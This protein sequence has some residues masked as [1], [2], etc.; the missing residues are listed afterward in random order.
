MKQRHTFHGTSWEALED[1]QL[2]STASSLSAM[3][4]AALHANRAALLA[5]RGTAAQVAAGH[6]HT[7]SK[8]SSA[9]VAHLRTLRAKAA[10]THATTTTTT[11]TTD[12]GTGLAAA[13]AY[14][15]TVTANTPNSPYS[16]S[17]GLAALSPGSYP[18]STPVGTTTVRTMSAPQSAP[19]APVSTTITTPATT[20]TTVTLGSTST[21]STMTTPAVTGAT[22]TGSTGSVAV[23]TA[24]P[25][26]LGL[27]DGATLSKA[28]VAG[29]KTAVATFAAS[30]TYG[31][32]ATKDQA[33]AVA[34]EAAF[35]E[36]TLTAWSRTQVVPA[37][38]VTKLQQAINS[39][40]ATYT[41]G[42]NAAQDQAAWTS[43][44]T[45]LNQ[46]ASNVAGLSTTTPQA[47]GVQPGVSIPGTSGTGSQ[48][49][50]DNLLNGTTLSQS[51]M[52]TLQTAVTNFAASYTSG[53]N[54]TA[55]QAATTALETS[56]AGLAALHWQATPLLATTAPTA[57]TTTTA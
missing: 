35:Q 49:L 15:P 1:R 52:A 5:A 30:Y 48:A 21:S 2:L 26:M 56:L 6:I 42:T 25:V 7:T 8:A 36:I 45:S 22:S 17:A 4:R 18:M 40:A 51:E 32:N 24:P 16:S 11:T 28:D 44:E 47:T 39:F 53:T 37:A 50:L 20:S 13:Y 54:T 23:A 9:A 19:V 38:S 55:D 43:L 34:L 33:A 31:V 29:L 12:T 41:S 10:A 57:T 3:Q 14:H 27:F 46:F